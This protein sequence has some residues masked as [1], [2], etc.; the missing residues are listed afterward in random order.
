MNLPITPADFSDSSFF[1]MG[2][3]E[4]L[5]NDLINPSICAPEETVN[6]MALISAQSPRDIAAGASTAPSTGPLIR[7]KFGDFD[8]DALLAFISSH[9]TPELAAPIADHLHRHS[10][11]GPIQGI[12]VGFIRPVTTRYDP[13]PLVAWTEGNDTDVMAIFKVQS[14]A[15]PAS[16]LMHYGV[17]RC[18]REDGKKWKQSHIAW[19]VVDMEHMAE[20]FVAASHLSGFAQP[21]NSEFV[22]ILDEKSPKT[23]SRDEYMPSYLLTLTFC[24]LSR[25]AQKL[26]AQV[27]RVRQLHRDFEALKQSLESFS[28]TEGKFRGDVGL[29]LIVVHGIDGKEFH[30]MRAS[31]AY[32]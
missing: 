22:R 12:R 13:W 21:S 23:C 15:E 26:V 25:Y 17:G 3:G 5:W 16:F 30:L 18:W 31:M 14:P 20:L 24:R 7:A 10:A 27:S 8:S 32:P 28:S 2:V 19:A 29:I 4:P 1:D 6:P 9:T 11:S